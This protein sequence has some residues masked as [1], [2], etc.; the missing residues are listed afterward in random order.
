MH[1]PHDFSALLEASF[2]GVWQASWQG[3]VAIG[4]VMLTRWA[5]GT[6]VPARWHHLLWFLV[7]ARLLV[8]SEALPHT[9]TS[10][11]NL[12]R[13][14]HASEKTA[15]SAIPPTVPRMVAGTGTPAQP[16]AGPVF[17]E[18]G[19]RMRPTAARAD[20]PRPWWNWA[21][22][23]W[24]GGVGL[25]GGWLAVCHLKLRRRLRRETSP[26]P[27]GTLELWQGCCRRWLRRSAPRLLAADWIASPALVGWRRPTLL[28][29]R[30]AL[31]AFSEEDWEHVFAH[32]IAH[33]RWR[34]HW[35]QVLM[36][37]AWCVHWFNPVVWV[38]FRR[39]RADRELA[40][41]EW[42]LKH[43]AG[44]ERA[45]AYGETLFKTVANQRAGRA[46]QPGMVGISEDGAQIK[47][48]LQ[49]IAAFLPQRRVIGSLAGLGI[50]LLLASV[51]LGQGTAE[52]AAG[53][54]AKA[55][56]PAATAS[57]RP[58]AKP[59]AT[60]AGS[61]AAPSVQQLADEAGRFRADVLAAARAGDAAGID[62]LLRTAGEPR[63]KFSQGAADGMLDDALRAGNLTEFVTLLDAVRKTFFG[64]DCKIRDDRLADLVK[65]GRTDLLDALLARRLD[66][67]RLTALAGTADASTA[68]WIARRV[69]EVGKARAD[70]EALGHAARDGDLPTLNRLLDAGVDVNAVDDEDST[71]LIEAVCK[72][73]LDAARRLLER[74][75]LVDKVRLPGWNYTPL[76]LVTSVEMAQLLKDHGANVHAKLFERNASILTYVAMFQNA[77]VVA[78][79]LRQGLDPKMIG[80]NDE[81][82]LF[83][84]GDA[85]TAKLLIAAGVDPNRLSEFGRPPISQARSAAVA[86][87]LIDGGATITGFKQPL[88]P[89][90]IQLGG[91]DAIEAV[92]KAGGEHDPETLQKLLL[93]AAHVDN[94][95][96]A[97]VLLQGGA[98]PN[99]PGIW[100]SD[101]DKL[102]PLQTC[103][104]F[105]SVKVAKVLLA[106]GAD[107]NGG[108]APGALLKNAMHNGYKELSE[109]LRQAGAKGVSDLA[110]ALA[111]HDFGKVKAL[112]AAAP[113]Y[114]DNP[115][116]WDDVLPDAARIGD[117]ETVRAA[118][119]KGV[120]VEA[121]PL[122]QNA[123]AYTAAAEEGQE[124]ALTMLLTT[125][126]PGANPDDLRAA[127]WEA[128]WN[129]HPYPNQRSAEHFEH[130]VQML[131]TAGAPVTGYAGLTKGTTD[132]MSTAVFSRNPGGNP[133][134][135]EML[136]RAGVDPNPVITMRDKSQTRLLDAVRKACAEGQCSTPVAETLAKLAQL[137][138]P[139]ADA[140]TDA[141]PNP[142]PPTSAATPA[143]SPAATAGEETELPPALPR[144]LADLTPDGHDAVWELSLQAT[145]TG[146]IKTIEALLN[147]G[148]DP[149][150]DLENSS[151]LLFN[152]VDDDQLAIVKL[153]LAHGANVLAKTSWGD[154]PLQ[155]ACWRGYKDIADALIQAGAP[156]NELHYDTG[157]GDVAALEAR[158]QRQPITDKEARD[159]L[160]F[161]VASGHPDTFEFLWKKLA[162]MPDA[163]KDK[164]LGDL[165]ENAGKWG[166]PNLL[167]VLEARGASA[168]KDGDR[169]LV[170]ALIWNHVDTVKTLLE[171]GGPADIKQPRWGHLLR[172]AA[173]DGHLESVRLL[174]DHGA[175]INFQ[176]DHGFT[177]L[178][179]AAY[180][181]YDDVCLLL[182]ARGAD[183]RIEDRD[184]R[185]AAWHAAGGGPHCD[186]ALARMM[187]AG[188]PVNGTDKGGGTILSYMMH[189]ATPQFLHGAFF[190]KVYSAADLERYNERE[191][192]V[193][194]LL[195]DAGVDLN[196]PAG[197]P[198]PLVEA[199]QS[200]QYVGALEL[201]KRGADPAR[202]DKNGT[203]PLYELVSF[204]LRD[205]PLPLELLKALA[206][207]G[208]SPGGEVTVP[209]V[210]PAIKTSALEVVIGSAARNTAPGN[211]YREGVKIMLDAGGSF[212][213]VADA[214]VQSL[215]QGA[216]RGSLAAVQE[217]VGKG[218]PVSAADGDGWDALAVA[219]ALG[220]DNCA[221]WLLD[222]GA[223]VSGKNHAEWD[224]VSPLSFAVLR[225]Q[226]DLVDKL[227]A[228][229]AKAGGN[230]SALYEAVDNKNQ[231]IFDA[232][233]RAG[234]DPKEE[235]HYTMN[236]GSKTFRPPESFALFLCI[237]NGATGMATALLDHGAEADP[238]N[239]REGRSLA[240][241][242]VFYDRPQILRALLDHG[243]NPINLD[244]KGETPLGLAQK[245]HPELVG[246]LEAAEKRRDAAGKQG[247]LRVGKDAGW[248]VAREVRKGEEKPAFRK[249]VRTNGQLCRAC[250][251][252]A[253]EEPA[254]SEV[255][256][257]L[258]EAS[259]P[260][261]AA[262]TL[263]ATL[264]HIFADGLSGGG[265]DP[266]GEQ[267]ELRGLVPDHL[268]PCSFA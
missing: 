92:L 219:T 140:K 156:V 232:L 6:R 224:W 118:L 206:E 193:I 228:H 32:E 52:P 121:K 190:M 90:M 181:G 27:A 153:L 182:L 131:L 9:R 40:A 235:P 100:A 214:N 183:G 266:P 211:T 209:N 44:S 18:A 157:M 16:P 223:D 188:V 201:L 108:S 71:A 77:D 162:P 8:P 59:G 203:T 138:P 176:D 37:A 7:L 265:H 184:G 25:F 167:P 177:S 254:H 64:K 150:I 252:A 2:R 221:E 200:Q 139:S 160:S 75:A 168:T 51:V 259:L 31:D 158:D 91:G 174:L 185:N 136:A 55:A 14:A 217:S 106:A 149:N 137:S 105:G 238:A 226:A 172:D 41:D 119:A 202:V 70:V 258:G 38:G 220:Y 111:T 80:D 194:D 67:A 63:G 109:V 267:R 10:L 15:A 107:P 110:F 180:N 34:D 132:L 21:A 81:N 39:L 62:A 97:R 45:L 65:G 152:A 19:P 13:G 257:R 155:R 263:V 253:S 113:T 86:Q 244:D 234:A 231:R 227:L 212:P 85:K 125:R 256:G 3:A 53:P 205:H 83:G 222:H 145:K 262:P 96:A 237:Q 143:A 94:D 236:T 43:L 264:A 84:V 129:C 89:Q 230:P 61:P 4:L 122:G 104:I 142:V 170:Q 199:M 117:V 208:G 11:E 189:F 240:Y 161:A 103:C 128:V 242:A 261:A 247:G 195:A 159:G 115:G 127:L 134:V 30:E 28:V 215:L 74:G 99:E 178:S 130:C 241:W 141:T 124:A 187:K 50:V 166:H 239:L 218:A 72:N 20:R 93:T 1:S 186:E 164:L 56:T 66:P 73:R 213:G 12:W 148:L 26:V 36:L 207:R 116:F 196:G 192:R 248:K 42:V 268:E 210:T 33:L 29:P 95:A 251:R 171:R 216:A 54:A 175:N 146:D 60:P 69:A 35:S 165:Y 246:V 233:L 47:Q 169:A 151:S 260:R 197:G 98:K 191:R 147:R 179:W 102:L 49:R 243:A 82:L 120:P 58:E 78:W 79:F 123:D 112:L 135:M 229:G 101:M 126:Q 204:T 48:R 5:C 24:L 249:R 22:R 133:S 17:R 154:V 144:N 57:P 88:L 163:D 68:A 245:S 250:R 46:F 255:G 87:A 23:G 198:V 76:C 225:N 114:Q 173:G